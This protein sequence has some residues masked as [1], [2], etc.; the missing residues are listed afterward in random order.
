MYIS[1][2]SNSLDSTIDFK[3]NNKK[4]YKRLSKHHFP[5]RL[6][7]Q[8]KTHSCEPRYLA[9]IWYSM[10]LQCVFG[11]QLLGDGEGGVNKAIGDV[12]FTLAGI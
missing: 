12:E 3:C 11:M 9:L 6:P 8:T 5:L 10:N 1:E 2:H 7:Q 4:Q